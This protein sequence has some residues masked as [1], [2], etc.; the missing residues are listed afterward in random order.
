MPPTDTFSQPRVKERDADVGVLG[1]VAFFVLPLLRQPDGARSCV[2]ADGVVGVDDG[3]GDDT[4]GTLLDLDEDVGDA[5]DNGD[6]CGG[7]DDAAGAGE[8]SAGLAWPSVGVSGGLLLGGLRL[9]TPAPG[10]VSLLPAPPEPP[11]FWKT[12]RTACV[13]LSWR[14]TG[15]RALTG[16]IVETSSPRPTTTTTAPCKSLLEFRLSVAVAG[17][18]GVK[19]PRT[20]KL[21]DIVKHVRCNVVVACCWHGSRQLVNA[22]GRRRF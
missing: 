22:D 14:R 15:G 16:S 11:S 12:R 19:R 10:S 21:A 2:A 18:S 17:D 8:C 20:P 5:T 4:S 3:D 9:S 7:V 1:V 6:E 13:M